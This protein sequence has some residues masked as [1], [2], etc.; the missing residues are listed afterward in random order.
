MAYL[1]VIKTTA[2]TNVAVYSPS[3]G[4]SAAYSACLA[5]GDILSSSATNLTNSDSKVYIMLTL[6]R[7]QAA[8][9]NFVNAL[10]TEATA[11]DTYNTANG[12]TITKTT[13]VI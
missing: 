13:Y 9:D 11:R 4:S 3:S 10:T 7:D 8:H 12:I 5:N 2:P 1:A 6:W